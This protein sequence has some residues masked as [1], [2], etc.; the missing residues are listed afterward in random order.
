MQECMQYAEYVLKEKKNRRSDEKIIKRTAKILFNK[1]RTRWKKEEVK[2]P[3][4]PKEEFILASLRPAIGLKYWELNKDK[5]KRNNGIFVRFD[6][7][8]KLKPIPT[9]F[10]KKW[11]EE[12][13]EEYYRWAYKQQKNSQKQILD[14]ISQMK[15]PDWWSYAQ[16]L[17][18]LR[19]LEKS[20][21]ENKLK[22]SNI[23]DRNN[24]T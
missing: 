4:K 18:H 10:K 22:K 17:K 6:N 2:D 9:Y 12:N 15:L 20:N 7:K 11:K 16:K 3:N 23:N 8:V 13:P 21:L 5:I 19:K 14:R 24:F 1:T